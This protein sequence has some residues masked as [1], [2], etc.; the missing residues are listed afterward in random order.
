[1]SQPHSSIETRHGLSPATPPLGSHAT[2]GS[3]DAGNSAGTGL[4][5][6]AP[7]LSTLGGWLKIETAGQLGEPRSSL[8]LHDAQT[9]VRLGSV[10]ASRIPGDSWRAA[11]VRAPRRPFVIVAR[12]ADP[13]HWLA[14]SEPVEMSNLSFWAWQACRHGQLLTG[15]A[16]TTALL[17][18]IAVMVYRLTHS[19]RNL[20]DPAA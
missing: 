17:L 15:V 20:V 1:M 14:F 8:E 19:Q 2:W 16:A 11:Y 12:D 6:S 4:W 9:G 7:L 10:R 13:M 5:I 3:H 18:G